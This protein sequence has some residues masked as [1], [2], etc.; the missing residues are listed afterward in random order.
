MNALEKAMRR[1][2]VARSAVANTTKFPERAA[3]LVSARRELAIAQ[4]QRQVEI[5]SAQN[6]ITPAELLEAV[7]AERQS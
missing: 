3:D 2:R 4:V 6:R 1:V 5:S 7:L